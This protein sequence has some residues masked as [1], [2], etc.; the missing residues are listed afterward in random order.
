MVYLQPSKGTCDFSGAQRVALWR[1]KQTKGALRGIA[2]AAR[3][4]SESEVVL[5]QQAGR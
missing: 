3:S 2:A 5:A 4:L 1:M